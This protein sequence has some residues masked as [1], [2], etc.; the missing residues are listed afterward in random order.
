M[1]GFDVIPRR[2]YGAILADPPWLFKARTALQTANWGVRRDAEKHYSV[3]A[4]SDIAALPIREVAA[5][6]CH[7]FL[8]TTGP[9]LRL[10]FDVIEAWGFRY[11]AVAFTWI[12]LRRSHNPQQ[13]RVL[14]TAESDLHVGLGLTTRKNAEF[15][16]LGRRGNAHR[17]AKD[18]REIIMTP[19]RRH[20]QK[21]DEARERIERYCDGPYLELFARDV[22]PG[23]DSYGDEIGGFV[24]T[25][26]RDAA[27]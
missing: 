10:S 6:D 13:L 14:P 17:N 20:S 26:E 16:L 1:T 3:M 12:K 4:L 18:V 5:P 21:P 27:E 7:L 19:V 9:H 8:W 22:R 25:P 23:W 24:S 2:R 15:C 11:S